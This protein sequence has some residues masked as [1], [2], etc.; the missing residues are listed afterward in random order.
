MDTLGGTQELKPELNS[1]FNHPCGPN[2][3]S[4]KNEQK[5][6][7]QNWTVQNCTLIKGVNQRLVTGVYRKVDK[8]L[9]MLA[10]NA[11]KDGSC[12]HAAKAAGHKTVPTKSGIRALVL[13]A[14]NCA[15]VRCRFNPLKM[16]GLP[17]ILLNFEESNHRSA[18]C[19][20]ECQV[21]SSFYMAPQKSF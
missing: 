12:G 6:T 19:A 11:F 1:T 15:V 2:Q 5:S 17:C 21:L 7:V 14:Q 4:L 18:Q 20:R 9:Q 16:S 13:I 10:N 3:L 8:K